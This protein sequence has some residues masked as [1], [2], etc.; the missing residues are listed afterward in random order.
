MHHDLIPIL[1]EDIAV[2]EDLVDKVQS[3]PEFRK[4][5]QLTNDLYLSLNG[6]MAIVE[7]R[8]L[9]M[10]RSFTGDT[11]PDS[12]SAQQERIRDLLSD[13]MAQRVHM[14]GL[15]AAL[16][17]LC[18]TVKL[19]NAR[20]RLFLLPAISRALDQDERAY[21]VLDA[22][23]RPPREARKGMVRRSLA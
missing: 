3:T 20:E 4:K 5:Q 23:D 16:A 18:A 9:P 17:V 15:S 19:Q 22:C 13:L 21:L 12:F 10:L 14:A 11:L 8:V 2:L 1:T 6:H 7:N